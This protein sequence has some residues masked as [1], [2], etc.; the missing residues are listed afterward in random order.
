MNKIFGVFF[1]FC[2]LIGFLV[3]ERKNVGSDGG[4]YFKI[5]SISRI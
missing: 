4:L 2:V 3:A 1:V 5:L